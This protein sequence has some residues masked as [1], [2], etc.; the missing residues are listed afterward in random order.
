APSAPAASTPP[1]GPRP[2]AVLPAT[3]TPAPPPPGAVNG[4]TF[5]Q[6][7]LGDALTMQPLLAADAVSIDR[8]SLM[9]EGLRARDPETLEFR[10]ALAESWTLAP[11]NLG[12]TYTLREGLTWSDGRPLTAEDFKF[13][14]D[15]LTDPATSFPA[16]GLLTSIAGLETPDA[17]TL[18]FRFRQLSAT[19]FLVTDL[20]PPI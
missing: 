2:A 7:S 6:A 15:A 10:P 8:I 1:P 18:V 19:A 4:G 5:T 17:R 13:T 3:A 14:W 16:R 12:V 20:V 11:D 9:Y